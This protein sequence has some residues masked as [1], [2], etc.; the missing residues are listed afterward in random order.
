MAL[1][2][3]IGAGDRRPEIGGAWTAV[4]DYGQRMDHALT[5]FEAG[6][7]FGLDAFQRTACRALE[8]GLVQAP[9]RTRLAVP[10][11][12]SLTMP[13]WKPGGPVAVKVV[14][15][16]E[17]NPARGPERPAP[18]QRDQQVRLRGRVRRGS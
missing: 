14:N 13:S 11:G 17:G 10:G 6:Y 18:A 3:G 2:D 8:Q 7:P 9:P 12:F 15:V 1:A 16:F 5:E 4:R